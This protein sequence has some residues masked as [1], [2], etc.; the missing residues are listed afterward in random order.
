MKSIVII[1]I[2]IIIIKKKKNY[3]CVFGIAISPLHC[4]MNIYIH[5]YFIKIYIHTCIAYKVNDAKLHCTT[6]I[7]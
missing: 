6:K 5:R 4:R 7:K 3:S 1:M 2:M